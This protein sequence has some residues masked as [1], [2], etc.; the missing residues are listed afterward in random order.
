MA[1]L[2]T[3]GAGYLGSICASEL[4]KA[5]G[6]VVVYDNFSTG[7]RAAVGPGVVLVEGTF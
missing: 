3:G 4:V 1:V 5:G 6:E 2:V 7:H